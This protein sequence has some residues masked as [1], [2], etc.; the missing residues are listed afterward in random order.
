HGADGGRSPWSEPAALEVGLLE[1]G[2]WSAHLVGP[3]IDAGFRGALHLR[4][5]FSADQPVVR[6]RLHVTA[7]GGVEPYLNGT[8][9]GDHVLDPGWTS[10]PH[11]VCYSTFDVADALR[12][13]ENVLGVVVADG[14]YR[15]RLGFNG[16]RRE[17]YGGRLGV[18]AQLEL[19][20]ADG[21]TAVV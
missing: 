1:P 8:R 5:S 20:Y 4:R 18:L 3:R 14:W 6:A 11:R 9:G 21:T 13:G 2:D 16:G 12:V 17:V 10:Y 15:G 19:V 7:L